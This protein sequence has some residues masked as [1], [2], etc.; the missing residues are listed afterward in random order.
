MA[1][2]KDKKSLFAKGIFAKDV[3]SKDAIN[4][5]VQNFY[6]YATEVND[7]RAVPDVRDG[8]I[9]VQRR[10]L[11]T[12]HDLRMGTNSLKG[13]AEVV[14][15]SM[16]FHPHADTSMYDS[17]KKLAQTDRHPIPLIVFHG[18]QGSLE[19]GGAAMRYT[20]MRPSDGA[21][22]MFGRTDDSSAMSEIDYNGVPLG[23]N[24]DGSYKEAHILPAAFPNYLINGHQHGI[25]VGIKTEIPKHNAREVLD[26]ALHM[27][28]LDS[29]GI[30]NSTLM[31]LIPGPDFPLSLDNKSGIGCTIIDT[32]DNGIESYLT[33]GQ[34]SFIMQA[35]YHV[36]KYKLNKKEEGSIIVID[37]L[38]YAVTSENV[39]NRFNTMVEKKILPDSI[40]CNQSK[41]LEFDIHRYAPEDVLPYLFQTDL[42]KKFNAA[43]WANIGDGRQEL[44]SAVDAVIY[45]LDHRKNVVRSV[46]R[47]KVE[48][49][50]KEKRNIE[51]NL[52][53]IKHAKWLTEVSLNSEKPAPIVA[54]KLSISEEQA[55][56]LLDRTTFT[57]LNEK[58]KQS[59]LDKIDDLEERIDFNKSLFSD[60]E[61][62]KREIITQ[63][64][65]MKKKFP[66]KRRCEILSHE[67]DVFAEKPK[68]P[69]V[70][71][72]P[73]EGYLAI[74]ERN[75]IRWALRDN[76]NREL[77]DDY[78]TRLVKSNDSQSIFAISNFGFIYRMPID[79]APKNPTSVTLHLINTGFQLEQGE[80]ILSVYATNEFA[81][82]NVALLTNTGRLKVVRSELYEDMRFGGKPGLTLDL[83]KE[84]EVIASCVFDEGN[85]VAVLTSTGKFSMIE[86][87]ADMFKDKG[88]NA[89]AT[90]FVKIAQRNGGDIVWF[91]VIPDD[92]DMFIYQNADK[93][94]MF[95]FYDD[96]Y[97]DRLNVIGLSCSGVTNISWGRPIFKGA[98][99]L[100][101]A[102]SDFDAVAKTNL[103]EIQCGDALTLKDMTKVKGSD[104]IY[105]TPYLI[106]S[107]SA[108]EEIV[109]DTEEE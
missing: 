76:I 80:E 74:G 45:W 53:A 64:Q 94:G 106:K 99:T 109:D 52:L 98:D 95:E 102:S 27:L 36:E 3:E 71:E 84:D 81:G 100:A 68:G 20:K 33:T 59:L 22:M 43:M 13:S 79:E 17:T 65:T 5:A 6:T 23:D 40:K 1:R 92:A 8:L 104:E 42:R 41:Q 10:A 35:S 63:I 62:L 48:R 77:N 61:A 15:S 39:V 72:P 67:D 70:M 29:S 103:S 31:K 69:M 21:M 46:A 25:G 4:T 28:K 14:G 7:S 54:K 78:F 83:N 93:F 82:K 26:L 75:N 86:M 91:G 9:D 37:A 101:V 12:M 60:D 73:K 85:T 89:K 16:R 55:Q 47:N 105:A 24:Y 90:N 30:R 108:I 44:V 88:A 2:R 97:V 87:N 32:S 56:E 49:L 96:F 66:A 18:N 58:R 11:Y 50:S 19:N 51:L 107:E 57:K 38:P 34:G